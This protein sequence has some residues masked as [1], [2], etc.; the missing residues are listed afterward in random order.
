M[1]LGS[2]AAIAA[3]VSKMFGSTTGALLEFFLAERTR[4][5]NPPPPGSGSLFWAKDPFLGFWE[6]GKNTLV[7]GPVNADLRIFVL[8]IRIRIFPSGG[9]AVIDEF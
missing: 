7:T 4:S 1:I 5:F 8:L 6:G 2:K 9:I 3:V